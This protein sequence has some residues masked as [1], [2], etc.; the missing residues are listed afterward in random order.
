[1]K[2]ATHWIWL[3]LLSAAAGAQPGAPAESLRNPMLLG[4]RAHYGFIIPHSKDLVGVSNSSP[5]GAELNVQW[6]ETR[7][8]RTRR[9]GVVA[10]RGFMLQYI[11]YDNP[12][13]LGSCL[14]GA[15][16]V[17]PLIRPDRRLYGSVQ[18]GIGV[19][20]L[21]RVYDAET[22]PTNLFF[23]TPV[24]FFL[25]TNAYLTFKATPHWELSLGFNYNHISNGGMKSP[26]KGMNFPTWNAG[27]AYNLNPTTIRRAP[28]TQDWKN[29]P[30]NFW[31]LHAVGSLKTV[32]ANDQFPESNLRWLIGGIAMAGRRVGRV[33][34]LSAGTEWIHDG[35]RRG[36]LDRVGDTRSALLG[37]ILAGHELLSGRV[38]FTLHIGIYVHNPTRTT[39]LLYQ[40][41]GL[42]YLTGKHLQIG[43]TLKAHRHEADVFD[44]RAGWLW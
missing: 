27:A 9:S 40:R 4:L 16:F 5:F 24:S 7:E 34:A 3:M 13:V 30:R 8:E 14:T 33:S 12:D 42:F 26:N 1:M 32:E 25:M 41:Y 28:K 37:G 43:T 15:A 29:E 6:I 38:R 20:Y 23:S 21:I 44:I 10:K 35:A 2:P 31:Y 36:Q 22:N 18:M 39:D 17:E 19:S 11:N